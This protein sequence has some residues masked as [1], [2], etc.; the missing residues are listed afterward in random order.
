MVDGDNETFASRAA[1]YTAAA[2]ANGTAFEQRRV[3]ELAGYL[4][5][6]NDD[7]E[8]SVAELAQ[9]NQLDPIV[10]YWQAVANKN[11]GDEDKAAAL[12]SQAAYRNTLSANLPLFRSAA[13]TLLED[14]ENQ[15]EMEAE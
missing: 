6:V 1:E 2:E 11:A 14:L 9:A 15:E 3:H 12:A 4:A 13:I 7:H 10:L 5:S 8:T